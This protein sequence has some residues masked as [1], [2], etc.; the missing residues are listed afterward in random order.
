M[1]GKKNRL[2]CHCN[3]VTEYEILRVLKKGAKNFDEVS[4]FTLASTN[5]GRCKPEIVAITNRYFLGK[6]TDLQQN[7][8]F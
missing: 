1:A 5:C 4:K 6:K 7:I 8:E 3:G 2:I